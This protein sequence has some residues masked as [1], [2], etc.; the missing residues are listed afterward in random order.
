MLLR[1]VVLVVFQPMLLDQN[2]LVLVEDPFCSSV[3]KVP[4]DVTF[5]VTTTHPH[6]DLAGL[7]AA[8]FSGC[9]A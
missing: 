7:S 9:L 4:H 3:S 8:C 6:A 5:T 1:P 2:G